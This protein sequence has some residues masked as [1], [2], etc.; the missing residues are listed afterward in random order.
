MVKM[1]RNG[2][3]KSYIRGGIKKYVWVWG[4]R[5]RESGEYYPR[6]MGLTFARMKYR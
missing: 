4:A 3:F 1:V 2:R 6:W 5:E